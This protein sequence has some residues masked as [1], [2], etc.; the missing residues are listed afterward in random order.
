M[1][2]WWYLKVKSVWYLKFVAKIKK[3]LKVGQS[4]EIFGFKYMNHSNKKIRIFLQC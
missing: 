1:C 4:I 2:F 3:R